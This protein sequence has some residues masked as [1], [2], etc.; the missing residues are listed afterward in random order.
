MRHFLVGATLLLFALA[1]TF[2]IAS[3]LQSYATAPLRAV[4]GRRHARQGAGQQPGQQ[5]V[6]GRAGPQSGFPPRQPLVLVG[7]HLTL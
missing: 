5:A 2:G 7:P 4:T 3:V 1:A 6:A